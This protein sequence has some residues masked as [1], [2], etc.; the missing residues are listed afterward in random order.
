MQTLSVN[1]PIFIL[2]I[3]ALFLFGVVYAC[4][5]HL[6]SKNEVHGQTAYLV[7]AGVGVTLIGSCALI[8]LLN[9]G[10]LLACFTASGLPMVVE[11]VNR[12]HK[13][14]KRDKQ[15]AKDVARDLLG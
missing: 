7:V 6:L 9:V 4:F 13:A 5:V 12:T 10:L 11:Y 1:Y 15:D 14:Q 3:V 2:T 8:G